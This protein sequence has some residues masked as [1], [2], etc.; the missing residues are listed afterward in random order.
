MTQ[1]AFG[2]AKFHGEGSDFFAETQG[3]TSFSYNLALNLV[4][5]FTGKD[6]LYTR[7]RSGNMSNVYTDGLLRSTASIGNLSRSL[8]CTTASHR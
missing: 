2:A 7:L 6:T 1:W 5:S 8:A 3:G 4:T